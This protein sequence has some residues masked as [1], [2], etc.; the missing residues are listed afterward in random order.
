MHRKKQLSPTHEMYLKV[1][2][3]VREEYE[4]ARVRDIAKGLGVSPGTVSSGLKRLEKMG[5][6]QHDRY[7]VVQLTPEGTRV[8]ECMIR[9]FETIR[10]VLTDVLGVDPDT[11]ETD[12]CMMELAVSPAAV[13]RMAAALFLVRSGET[14]WTRRYAAVDRED[15]SCVEQCEAVG[16]CQAAAAG[17]LRLVAND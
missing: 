12:A 5:F 8:A 13:I 10:G 14:D 4:V 15:S 11:A 2:Y 6:V 9:R 16:Q 7:G 3:N 1:L 17:N